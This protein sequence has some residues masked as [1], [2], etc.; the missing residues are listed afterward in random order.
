MGPT[1]TIA[2]AKATPTRSLTVG[3]SWQTK[4]LDSKI[5]AVQGGQPLQNPYHVIVV[6]H[7]GTNVGC[8]EGVLAAGSPA[9]GRRP[10]I[11]DFG[12]S[13]Y[14]EALF[15]PDAERAMSYAAGGARLGVDGPHR[16]RSR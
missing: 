4:N 2:G 7:A 10:L 8:A 1:L 13:K 11:G 12:K 3:P 9:R 16:D 15:H 6:K 14:G 5:L